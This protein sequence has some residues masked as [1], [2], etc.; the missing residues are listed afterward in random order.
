MKSSLG[1]LISDQ[2]LTDIAGL[3]AAMTESE[4]VASSE[5]ISHRNLELTGTALR[6]GQGVWR[7]SLM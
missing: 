4:L 3:V 1:Q 2:I 7:F 5:R 6:G